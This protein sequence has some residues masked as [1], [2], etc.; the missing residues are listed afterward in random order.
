M[1]YSKINP[2][3]FKKCEYIRHR[4]LHIYYTYMYVL[5]KSARCYSGCLDWEIV[6]V[7]CFLNFAYLLKY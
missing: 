2:L 1:L 7:V 4:C 5:K 3:F 6:S